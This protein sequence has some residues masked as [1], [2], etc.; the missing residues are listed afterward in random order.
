MTQGNVALL[1][2]ALRKRCHAVGRGGIKKCV[3][4][5]CDKIKCDK[6]CFKNKLCDKI[7]SCRDECL[8]S[9]DSYSYAQG[10]E[11]QSKA[12]HHDRSGAF[13]RR[14]GERS[15]VLCFFVRIVF[16]CAGHILCGA[17][18]LHDRARP[19]HGLSPWPSASTLARARRN[20]L[21]PLARALPQA[22]RSQESAVRLYSTGN[23]KTC[24]SV[25][26]A[27]F[28]IESIQKS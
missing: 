6:Q 16:C 3:T 2:R 1:S 24:F 17:A 19:H 25:P 12:P 9:S 23:V 15:A 5:M 7:K 22:G 26:S 4:K 21:D 28:E 18:S 10:S 11:Q 13:K 20:T 27:H 8:H 14:R